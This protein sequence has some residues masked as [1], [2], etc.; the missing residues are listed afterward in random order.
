MFKVSTAL[1]NAMLAT[2]SFK[3]IMDGGFLKL[4]SGAVPASADDALGAAVLLVTIS[5]SAGGTGLTFEA[6]ATNG[7]LSKATAE[8]WQ[9][10]NAA[11]GTATF[12]R[13][14]PSAD[15]GVSST[16]EP[17]VQGNVGVIGSDLNLSN[18]SLTASAIQT[19]N[20]FNV[21][22]PTL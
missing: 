12:F 13:F 9:G 17:R 16:T 7:I 6:T 14:A 10:V 15:T 21:A 5:V 2:G 3:S 8:T 4:Y 11:S 18:T 22:L 1:R 19:I 20:H